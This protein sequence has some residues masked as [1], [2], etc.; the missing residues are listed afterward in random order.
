M[1]SLHLV[2]R[3]ARND[4]RPMF[5]AERSRRTA[6]LAE[7]G[8][9]AEILTMILSEIAA[10]RQQ[11]AV[12]SA[13]KEQNQ[14]TGDKSEEVKANEAD[15]ARQSDEVR[16][17]R[18]EL[19]ALSICIN[20]TKAEI[21]SI[22]P[23]SGGFDHLVNVS[24]ELDAVIDATESATSKILDAVELVEAQIQNI[25]S[26]S[27]DGYIN[28]VSDEV[29]ENLVGIYEACNFQDITGQR[30]TKVVNTLKFVEDR[31]SSMIDIW[32]A[33]SVREAAESSTLFGGHRPG[34]EDNHLLNGPQ[35]E[36]NGCNQDDIDALFA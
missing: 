19:R 26:H 24:N 28:S 22:Q 11:V 23:N 8:A 36:G 15:A 7:Q 33:D 5:T 13:D 35:L 14:D 2:P 3:Q 31:V 20:Q 6:K 32:G 25:K 4:D 34:H 21:A 16:M 12:L 30:I 9:N 18:T 1:T 29:M 27:Q 17:L 10:L